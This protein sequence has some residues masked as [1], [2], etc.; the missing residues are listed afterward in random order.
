VPQLVIA[1]FIANH[2]FDAYLEQHKRAGGR[3]LSTW[4]AA[5]IG[6]AMLIVVG[7][8]YLGVLVYSGV[9]FRAITDMQH[10]VDA[11]NGQEVYY[12]RGATR[13]E[14]QDVA[15]LLK[16]SGY[17][18]GTHEATVLIARRE[19]SFVVGEQAVNDPEMEAEFRALGERLMKV[20]N[21]PPLIVRLVDGNLR[22][23]KRIE[24]R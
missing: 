10:S 15:D 18:T 5:G 11:G 13:G 24:V 6:V 8:A 20:L 7:G 2:L 9:D 19:I 22:E 3:A 16:S 17:F 12:S 21:G 14:A 4:G 1:Y 23:M